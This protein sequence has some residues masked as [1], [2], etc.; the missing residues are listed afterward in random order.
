MPDKISPGSGLEPCHETLQV[1]GL[2]PL[3]LLY[4]GRHLPQ[5]QS[6]GPPQVHRLEAVG[7]Q[8][9]GPGQPS[10]FYLYVDCAAVLFKEQVNRQLYRRESGYMLPPGSRKNK[11]GN[12]YRTYVFDTKKF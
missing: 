3:H 12:W 1:P 11:F 10:A 5:V 9:K 7:A 2:A 8:G 6:G 4:C